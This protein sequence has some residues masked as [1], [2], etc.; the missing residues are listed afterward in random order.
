MEIARHGTAYTASSADKL[1][2]LNQFAIYIDL[3]TSSDGLNAFE[4]IF[5][6]FV[7]QEEMNFLLG[8]WKDGLVLH[9]RTDKQIKG[10]KLGSEEC[11]EGGEEDQVPDHVM[12]G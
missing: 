6:Y 5:S 12:T 8:Q 7:N 10:I 2:D 4:K 11:S 1:Q 9:L 3:T